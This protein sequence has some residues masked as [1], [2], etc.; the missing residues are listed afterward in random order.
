[1]ATILTNRL[2]PNVNRSCGQNFIIEFPNIDRT[3]MPYI[4]YFITFCC[5]F[6]VYLN[7]N[8]GNPFQKELVL[9]TTL[10]LV[11]LHSIIAFVAGHLMRNQ[12]LYK[13]VITKYYLLTS[14]EFRALRNAHLTL[15]LIAS[16]YRSTLS[17][18]ARNGCCR[19]QL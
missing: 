18:R 3:S 17:L 7:N 15:S 11:L 5:R 14:V 12:S 4:H 13:M 8:R 1:L 6:F 16:Q 19:A 10:S 9:F 2:T